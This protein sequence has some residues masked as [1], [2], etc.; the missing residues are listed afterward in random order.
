M[1][2]LIPMVIALVFLSSC[3]D[4]PEPAVEEPMVEA[5]VE[6][7]EG[8][9]E[10]VT[11]ANSATDATVS[12]EYDFSYFGTGS[13][14]D[15]VPVLEGSVMI[16]KDG[17]GSSSVRVDMEYPVTDSLG[18]VV[19][20]ALVTAATD[21]ESAWLIMEESK[22]FKYGL[23]ADGAD[24]LLGPVMAG[25]MYEYILGDPFTD[26]M[27]GE[28]SLREG[29]TVGDVD[30]QQVKVTYLGGSEAEWCFGSSD[31]LPRRVVR[32]ISGGNGGEVLELTNLVADGQMDPA[33]FVLTAPEGY[34]TEEYMSFLPVG[35]MAPA[36]EMST[37]DGGTL[38]LQD[39]G[40]SIVVMD[41]WATWCG[42]CRMVMPALQEIHETYEE[43]GVVVVGVNVWEDADPVTFMAEEGYTYTLL[44]N[45]DPVADEYLVTGIPTFYVIGRGGDI[46][47]AA[48]GADPA[49]EEA[50]QH[51]IE[52]NLPRL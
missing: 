35:S 33:S 1:K 18:E 20:T 23:L 49:N 50:L 13:L 43:S 48:R 16:L 28:L 10:L 19:S 21:G 22:A 37:P 4:S 40:G 34:T 11:A 47:F 6:V 8:G 32:F 12:V 42:P 52:V 41:F 2:L 14:E 31:L 26:E 39:L 36:W 29:M 15:E 25:V 44:L 5:P 7:D 45:G 3:G 27:A 38:S 17:E 51:V 46:L 9:L 30:C 24:D